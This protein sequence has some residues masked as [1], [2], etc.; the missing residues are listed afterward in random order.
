M[1]GKLALAALLALVAL[2]AALAAGWLSAHAGDPADSEDPAPLTLHLEADSEVCTAGSF[3]EVRW[4]ISGG[5]APYETTLN[6]QPVETP[7]SAAT[8]PCG[9]ALNIPD[10]LRGIV[11][12]APVDVELLVRDA[13]GDADR[14]RLT[15]QT[16]PSFPARP[17]YLHSALADKEDVRTALHLSVRKFRTERDQERRYLVRWRPI[18]EAEWRYDAFQALNG[19]NGRYDDWECDT[20]TSGVRFEAQTARV[21]SFAERATP[22]LLNWS[23]SVYTTTE[24]APLDLT[25][26]VTHD[27]IKL[28]WGP[29]VDGLT[30]DVSL[31]RAPP[32]Y[33]YRG[34]WEQQRVSGRAPYEITYK[35]LLPNTHYDV[36]L[37][38]GNS[39][40]VPAE[41]LSVRTA[42]SPPGWSREPRRPQ[43]VETIARDDGI[44]VAWDPPLEGSE[45][46]YEVVLH[47][48]GAPLSAPVSAEPDDRRVFFERRTPDRTY[49]VVVRHLGIENEEARI[50]LQPESAKQEGRTGG[51]LPEWSVV[52]RGRHE[53]R[54][55]EYAVDWREPGTDVQVQWRQDGR[56]MTRMAQ[57]PPL[58]LYMAEP[59]PYLFRMRR[60]WQRQWS[61]WSTL[62]RAAVSPPAPANIEMWERSGALVIEWSDVR[63][64]TF[65]RYVDG[66]RVYLQRAGREEQVFDAGTA[67]H[68]EIP[69]ATDGAEYRVRVVSYSD[70]LGESDAGERTWSQGAPP[71]LTLYGSTSR[72]DRTDI[73]DPF[74]RIPAL[75][76]WSISGGSAPY[77][78]HVSDRVAF[79]THARSGAIELVCEV[80]GASDE[81]R[82]VVALTDSIGRTDSAV[83]QYKVA[84][85]PDDFAL[86]DPS[87]GDWWRMEN[88]WGLSLSVQRESLWLL[89][90]YWMMQP[91]GEISGP[92][93]PIVVRWR[94]AGSGAWASHEIDDAIY[95]GTGGARWQLSELTPNTAYEVQIAIRRI[96]SGVDGLVPLAWTDVET[97]KTF[98]DQIEADVASGDSGVVVSWPAVEG[99][100]EYQVALHSDGVSWWRTYQPQ[101]DVIEDV[102]FR[103]ADWHAA[104]WAEVITPPLWRGEEQRRP[105]FDHVEPCCA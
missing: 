104:L 31:Q 38:V 91:N 74:Y 48:A 41:T 9:A 1:A 96:L 18:G 103:G 102:L 78:I 65:G 21:R 86:D 76:W 25:A 46:R 34:E 3:T 43:H 32:D 71:Q 57:R 95:D 66:Y 22:H 88:Q 92:A 5:A 28:S 87:T 15:L 105:G 40:T 47:E 60:Y 100:W 35:G 70:I 68:T 59:E 29:S 7:S 98:P 24:S 89:W 49:E 45:R 4:E 8:I 85:R 19:S 27:T 101:G 16:A 36:R 30:W 64:R 26:Q 14:E 37:S 11:P 39:L 79:E 50:V 69:I 52:Y 58:I 97:V 77:E 63:S 2:L 61:Q 53:E 55:H 10:W 80:G 42:P 93:G 84:V 13:N 23:D 82:A 73:C 44:V 17:A 12:P 99:A 81:L 75:V 51:P 54:G 94:E 20:N 83:V 90:R 72:S 67:T 56:W 6:G 62:R 33:V